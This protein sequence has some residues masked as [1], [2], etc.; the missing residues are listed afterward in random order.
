MKPIQIETS[1]AVPSDLVWKAWT[2]AEN[3]TKWFAPEAIV[4][5]RFGGPFELFF[6]PP[7]HDHMCTKGCVFTLV[8]PKKQLGFTWKG[9][10]QFAEL[11][12][13]PSSL[14]FVQVTFHNENG[15]ARI[16]LEHS[17]WG[18]SD[19]WAEARTWHQKA[20]EQALGRLKLFL[21]SGKRQL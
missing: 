21:K 6:T 13:N 9:P 16:T 2:K 11:M 5:A 18:D 17:G 1:I 19:A 7:D 12:N 14:T 10:D 15:N 4:E 20:W 3:I 8:E